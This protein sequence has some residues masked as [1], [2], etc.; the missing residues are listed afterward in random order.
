MDAIHPVRFNRLWSPKMKPTTNSSLTALRRTVWGNVNAANVS[1][2]GQASRPKQS[3]SNSRMDDRSRHDAGWTSTGGAG[4]CGP[5]NVPVYS[6]FL[7]KFS[8][9]LVNSIGKMNFVAGE[10]PISFS[11]SKYCSVIVLWST[12]CAIS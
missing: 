7:T 11:V 5:C 8:S 3:F 12:V 1:I 10:V 2:H 4:E 6:V 9:R